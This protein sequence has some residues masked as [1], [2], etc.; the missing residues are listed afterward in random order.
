MLA[1]ASTEVKNRALAAMAA[2]IRG[3]EQAI[4]EAN[5]H[6]CRN[7][8][9]R[10]E[11]DRLRLT[12]ERVAAMAHDVEAVSRLADPG[13]RGVRSVS[14]AQRAQDLEATGS[15]GRRRR[16]LRVAAERDERRGRDLREDRQRRCAARGQRGSRDESR[17]CRG[18]SGSARRR[19]TAR[20]R[21]AAHHVDR[22]GARGAD[23]EASRVSRRDHPQGRR[24]AHQD[25]RRER[26][27]AGHRDGRR[28]L[29]YVRGS[30]RRSGDGAADRLQRQGPPADDL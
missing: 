15:P 10:I 3:H 24:G 18:D 28:R 26:H 21:R 25:D 22:S 9:P 29:P 6:D 4:L 17:H 7:A 23:A 19:G 8:S 11:I 1:Q 16:R 2:A 30:R 27:G 14:A 13:R 20:D 12:P 5:A